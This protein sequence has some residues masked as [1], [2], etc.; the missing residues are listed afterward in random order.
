MSLSLGGKSDGMPFD[1]KV[2]VL[3]PTDGKF[4]MTGPMGAG[5]PGNLGPCALIDIDGVRVMVVSHKVQALDQAILRHVGVEPR[6]IDPFP[7]FRLFDPRA[8]ALRRWWAGDCCRA[9]RSATA[10]HNR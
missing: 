8:V 2:R 3:K 1:C 7:E 9:V 6:P 4:T 5:N 10:R